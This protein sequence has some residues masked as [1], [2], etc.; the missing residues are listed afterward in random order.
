M[1]DLILLLFVTCANNTNKNS[2]L[3][4]MLIDYKKYNFIKS[5]IFYYIK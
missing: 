2:I 1:P 4:N 5:N 3:Y